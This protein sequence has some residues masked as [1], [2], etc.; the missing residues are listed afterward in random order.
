MEELLK[1]PNTMSTVPPSTAQPSAA[2]DHCCCH[3]YLIFQM[4]FND[5][6]DG[7]TECCGPTDCGACCC[8]KWCMKDSV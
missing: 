5:T 3:S 6:A 8:D 4:N 7:L 2:S 1:V